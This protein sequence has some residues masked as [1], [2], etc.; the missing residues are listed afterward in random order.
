MKRCQFLLLTLGLCFVELTIHPELLIVNK[1]ADGVFG[2]LDQ[3]DSLTYGPVISQI[4]LKY[5]WPMCIASNLTEDEKNELLTA[6][7]PYAEELFIQKKLKQAIFDPRLDLH[8][9]F[10]PTALYELFC[11]IEF[12]KKPKIR[13]LAFGEPFYAENSFE[14]AG[15]TC[16]ANYGK[17][18]MGGY[19]E[20]GIEFFNAPYYEVYAKVNNLFFETND[21]SWFVMDSGKTENFAIFSSED[22]NAAMYI[23]NALVDWLFDNYPKL[24][25]SST[26]IEVSQIIQEVFQEIDQIFT[27]HLSFLPNNVQFDY[28]DLLSKKNAVIKNMMKNL[29]NESENHVVRKVVL[30]EY[31]ARESNKALILRGTS[32]HEFQIGL[33]QKPKQQILAGTTIFE[34]Q[35]NKFS[36]QSPQMPFEQKYKEKKL[37]PYSISFGNSLFAGFVLDAFACVYHFLMG[38]RSSGKVEPLLKAAGYALL[39]NK[40]EYV[41]SGNNRLFFIPPLA[42]IAA[43]FASGEFFHARTIAAT[44]IQSAQKI[45]V[46]GILAHVPFGIFLISRD[47]LQHAALFS[48]FL[49]KNGR[50]IQSGDESLFT[51]EEKDFAHVIQKAQADAVEFYQGVSSLKSALDK[52]VENVR[53]RKTAAVS[54]T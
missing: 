43:L 38:E 40:K 28:G 17:R 21:T 6:G 32:F 12:F 34:E 5:Q 20:F 24:K 18:L 46:E 9:I 14:K 41:E 13:H 52:K 37:T 44:L 25:Q 50:L 10:I 53:R 4:L 42:S 54:L 11:L 2:S 48:N 51:Q 47:P 7:V 22:E 27:R 16:V 15:M 26:A 3:L 8:V 19:N 29:K 36:D 30:L 45:N 31:E 39:I 35:K 49:A 1:M 33:G 23:N